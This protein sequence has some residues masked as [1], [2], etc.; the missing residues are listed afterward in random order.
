MAPRARS[1]RHG[2]DCRLMLKKVRPA[3]G[4][5]R[6]LETSLGNRSSSN[7]HPSR[8]KH[9]A[10]LDRTRPTL[11]QSITA[12]NFSAPTSSTIIRIL[13]SMPTARYSVN[14]T[15]ASLRYAPCR[16]CAHEADPSGVRGRPRIPENPEIYCRLSAAM[17]RREHRAPAERGRRAIRCRRASANAPETAPGVNIPCQNSITIC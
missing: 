5:G 17:A 7:R 11:S 12:S 1:R 9:A 15:R 8:Q 6:P 13:R 4:D 3:A 14:T 2:F 10:S 16:W